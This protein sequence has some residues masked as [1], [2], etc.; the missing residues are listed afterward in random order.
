MGGTSVQMCKISELMA[1]DYQQFSDKIM[2]VLKL[3]TFSLFSPQF[4]YA[5]HRTLKVKYLVK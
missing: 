5:V 3:R 4:S 1:R 2:P